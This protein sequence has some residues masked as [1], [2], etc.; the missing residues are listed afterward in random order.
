M[1]RFI[2]CFY[3]VFFFLLEA[4][5]LVVFGVDLGLLPFNYKRLDLPFLAFDVDLF[6]V[7][8]GVLACNGRVLMQDAVRVLADA[9][10]ARH[11]FLFYFLGYHHTGPKDV[12]SDHLGAYDTRDDRSGMD[13]SA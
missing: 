3:F 10:F 9:D 7:E 4:V 12:I 8:V 2:S 11:A 5:V 1:L 6:V 13:A